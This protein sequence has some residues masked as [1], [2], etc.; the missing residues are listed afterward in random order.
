[1]FNKLLFAF[2]IYCYNINTRSDATLTPKSPKTSKEPKSKLENV[3]LGPQS[4]TVFNRNLV[5]E[6]PLAKDILTNNGAYFKET[7][8]RNFDD[9]VL[10][11]VTPV[12][13]YNLTFLLDVFGVL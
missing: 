9:L 11:Y 6:T 5:T 12:S 3:R 1:M 8:Q 10:G 2:V 7:D 13:Y 4:Y